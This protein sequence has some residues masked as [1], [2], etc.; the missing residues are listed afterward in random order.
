VPA[1]ARLTAIACL[2][3]AAS[4]LAPWALAFDPQAW[5]VWAR[6]LPGTGLHPADGPSWK[7]LPVLVDVPLAL[8][9]GAA[10]ALWM[11]IARVG[12]LLALAGAWRLAGTLGGRAAAVGAAGVTLVGPWWAYTAALGNSEGWLAA[13]V[14]WAVVSHLQ[15]RP[16]IA[17]VWL[18]VAGLLRPEIWPFL[19]VYGVWMWRR[20]DRALP[21]ACAVIVLV[22]WFLPD[23]VWHAGAL[24]AGD[25]ARSTPSPASAARAEYPGLAVLADA[26]TGVGILACAGAGYAAW[27]SAR[28]RVLV[29]LALAYVL[30]VL[31]L[32]LV[33]YAGNPRYLVPALAL[34]AV[35]AGV[36]AS[37]LAPRAGVALLVAVTFAG[38]AGDLRDGAR[39]VGQ[40]ADLRRGLDA[41][42]TGVGGDA[43]LRRC[44]PVRTVGLTRALVA[45]RA[46]V[47][48][49][50]I[51]RWDAGP[52]STLL[53]P[54]P[55]LLQEQTRVRRRA[56][57]GER[58]VIRTDGW[59]IW[60][61]CSVSSRHG[62]A[63]G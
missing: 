16:R 29:A 50:G 21:A 51:T 36:G 35:A 17:L 4:L 48:L 27:R 60:S 9:G 58:L 39:D 28:A 53:P 56:R 26:A 24:S 18:T 10:P 41:A 31:V 34:I 46:G 3:A 38:H 55:T 61:S 11:V 49:P 44:G 14:L 15:G 22:A 33:G 54:P 5:L 32:T 37:R 52:G 8:A 6:D 12:A 59:A 20:G 42:I 45:L 43:A 7:P 40:R 25:S 1:S 13:G 19:G 2:L 47:P 62:S 30:I 63:S 23:L 57:P